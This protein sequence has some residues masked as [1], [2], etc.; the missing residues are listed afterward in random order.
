MIDSRFRGGRS[1]PAGMEARFF[2]SDN[3]AVDEPHCGDGGKKAMLTPWRETAMCP[4]RAR[5]RNL[6]M[7]QRHLGTPKR[8]ISVQKTA[9]T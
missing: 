4:A 1:T 9:R 3:C 8:D 6:P 7:S 2:V 5:W